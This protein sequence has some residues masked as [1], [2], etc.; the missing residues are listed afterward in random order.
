[1]QEILN[2]EYISEKTYPINYHE[3]DLKNVLKPSA[4]LNFLQ[5]MATINAEKLGFG[6]S[7]SFPNHYAWFLINYR[8]EF[9]DSWIALVNKGTFYFEANFENWKRCKIF[10]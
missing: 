10:K 2:S 3:V 8:M 4:L 6:P 5:D 1:M 7:F 9:Y